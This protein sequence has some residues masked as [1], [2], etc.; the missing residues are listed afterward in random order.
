MRY[1]FARFPGGKSKAITISYDDGC[2][3][4]LQFTQIINKYGLKATFN[5]NSD[6]IPIQGG[7]WR[8]TAE[9]L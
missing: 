1:R 7:Q 9:E 5:V 6:L 8:L 4:D 3:H 2:R